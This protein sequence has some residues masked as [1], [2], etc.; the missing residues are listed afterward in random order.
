MTTPRL[1]AIA[2]RLV[3]SGRVPRNRY[4]PLWCRSADLY[5]LNDIGLAMRLWQTTAK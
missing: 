5:N 4:R 3:S 1:I 2:R